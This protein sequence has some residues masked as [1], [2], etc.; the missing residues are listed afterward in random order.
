MDNEIKKNIP[1]LDKK[2][3]LTE[4]GWARKPLFIYDRKAIKAPFYRIKEWD[5]YLILNAKEEYAIAI[6]VSDLGYAGLFSISYIDYKLKKSTQCDSVKLLTRHKTGLS[7]S[8]Q[9][10]SEV[11][12]FDDK[13]TIAFVKKSN[14]R[15]LLFTAPDL[16][17]P[18]GTKGL[19]CNL[20]L[21]ENLNME[22]INIATSWKEKPTAFYLNRK[23]VGMGVTGIVRRGNEKAELDKNE[24][25]SILDWGRGRWTY[26][27]N[28]YWASAC[29]YQENI[30]VGFNFGYGFSDRSVA[31]ENAV[32]ANNRLYK[33]HDIKFTVPKDHMDNWQITD[34]EG[35]INLAFT[36]IAPRTALVKMGPIAS[37][38][39]QYFGYYYGTV[40][41]DD[42][43]TIKISKMMG[44]LEHV[45][46]KY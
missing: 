44:F 19:K 29:K 10:D 3:M 2:G 35:R 37:D 18:D 1:L 8:S 32:F 31:T 33:I 28:W 46:N 16:L 21:Y 25:L 30:V 27:N 38:Q 22:S 34:D 14:K 13:M 15:H 5:Y 24:A 9:S 26:K 20:T 45:F 11:S 12:Y 23:I 7:P 43:K 17:L 6:T 41:L 36:P 4:A 40:K 42:S 39:K